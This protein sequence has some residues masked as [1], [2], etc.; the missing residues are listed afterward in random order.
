MKI[1]LNSITIYLS[2]LACGSLQ[3][4]G[5]QGY[6]P[7]NEGKLLFH[8]MLFIINSTNIGKSAYSSI[9]YFEGLV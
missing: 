4:I 9:A 3:N 7:A 1:F 8:K 6:S 2:Q 5:T